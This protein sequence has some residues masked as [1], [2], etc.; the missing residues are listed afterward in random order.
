MALWPC[1]ETA[2]DDF[3]ATRT[4]EGERLRAVMLDRLDA[5]TVVVKQVRE[6]LR[7]FARDCA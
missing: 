6:W 7:I 4:R 5:I 3:I 2:L 1:L